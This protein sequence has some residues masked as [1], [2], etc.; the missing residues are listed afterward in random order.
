MSQCRLCAGPVALAFETALLGHHRVKFYRCTV[1]ESLQS[2]APYWLNEAY[3]SA[4]VDS[5]TGAVYRSLTCQAVIVAIAKSLRLKEGRFLDYGGGAGLLCRLLRDA[6]LDAYT[7]DKYAEPVYARAFSVSPESL[8]NC[9]FSLIAA[10]EVLEHS[11]EPSTEIGRL[12][13]MRPQILFATT[14]PYRGEGSE[15]WYIGAKYGQH[16]FFYSSKA[17]KMLADRY[18]YQYFGLEDFHVFSR[19]RLSLAR[20][21]ALRLGLSKAGRRMVS[22]WMAATRRARFASADFDALCVERP[23]TRERKG[24]PE[25]PPEELQER[26]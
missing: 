22:I 20:R 2:E 1:C 9:S 12:F 13:S 5:D 10:I 4:L 15:W 3:K 11:A 19:V 16:V 26:H 17:L 14:V 23:Q 8:S 7:Y 6:G 18:G 25:D 24:G 21:V